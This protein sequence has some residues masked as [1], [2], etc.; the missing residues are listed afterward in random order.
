MTTR[1]SFLGAGAALLAGA[2]LGPAA[3]SRPLAAAP[4]SGKPLDLL[5]LGGTGFIGPH[6]IEYALQR[7]HRVTMFNR[8]SKSGLY[9][10]RVEELTGDRDPNK[11]D[12][13]AALAGERRW[14]AVIDNSG[15]VPRHVRAS[16]VLLEGRVGRYLFTSTVAVYDY[17]AQPSVDRDGP[18]LPAP[19]PDVETVTGE[20]Y[21]PLKAEGDRIVRAVYGERATVVRPCYIVGP[22]DTTDRFTYW[23]DRLH[24][25]GD[26]V[27]PALPGNEVQWIDARDLCPW[28]IRLVENDTPGVFNGVGPASKLTNEQLMWGLRAFS[29]APTRLH[30]PSADLVDELK[31]PTPMFDWGR[32][33]RHTDASAAVAAGLTYHSLA[34]T[35]RDTQAWW[36][37]QPEERRAGA[38]R[39]PTAEQEAAM[40][41]RLRR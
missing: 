32:M 24:R 3:L 19:D 26:V 29:A 12:G 33:D 20:T 27:C 13:L 36:L 17:E 28:L 25:G 5:F 31:F 18:L 8:G 22:G 10:D 7:G 11:G 14:D 6:Q 37:A 15:Y 34:D 30:W 21:G 40:L 2:T 38:R 16:A 35:A 23:V 4:R 39:W 1:R 41:E 9:G